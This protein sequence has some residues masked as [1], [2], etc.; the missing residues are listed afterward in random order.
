[1]SEGTV[2]V[3]GAT[4]F[5]GSAVAR[6]AKAAGYAVRTLVRSSSRRDNLAGVDVEII[7]GD[8]CDAGSLTRALSGA[9]FLFHVAADYRLWARDTS[10]I[11][12]TNV[13]GTRNVMEAAL[14]AGVERIVHTSSVATLA[15]AT[16]GTSVSGGASG[17]AG[18]DQLRF[19]ELRSQS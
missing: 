18:C 7:E 17:Q 5:V 10:R 15:P 4:G 3:T 1:M 11:M 2:L 16:D 12:H 19:S 13:E 9:R 6:A 14:R 8:I